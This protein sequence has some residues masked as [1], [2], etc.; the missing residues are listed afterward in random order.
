M[1]KIRIPDKALTLKT[2][3]GASLSD[4][5]LA[6]AIAVPGWGGGI[7]CCGSGRIKIVTHP[8]P[9]PTPAEQ[10]HLS[11]RE[12]SDN[13]R[14][15]CQVHPE[16]D[17]AI[18]L[19]A[20]NPGNQF[21]LINDDALPAHRCAWASGHNRTHHCCGLAVDLGTTRIQLTLWDLHKSKRLYGLSCVN[22]Q[23][24]FGADILNRLGKAAASAQTAETLSRLVTES[25]AIALQTCAQAIPF[26]KNDLQRSCV[27]AN[28]AMLTLFSGTNHS[29]LLDPNSWTREIDCN[30]DSYKRLKKACGLPDASALTLIPPVAGFIGSDLIAAVISSRLMS[31]PETALLIDFGTNSEIALWDGRVLWIASAAGGPAF[32][33]CGVTCGMPAGHGAIYAVQTRGDG[34]PPAFSVTGDTS[35]RG[36]CGSGLIDAVA[37]FLKTGRIHPSGRLAAPGPLP[38]STRHP[39]IALHNRDIDIFQRAKAAIG[40]GVATLLKCAH[41][42]V[43]KLERIILCGSF[44]NHLSI[45]NAQALGLLPSVAGHKICLLGNAALRGCELLLQSCDWREQVEAVKRHTRFVDLARTPLFETLYPCHLF[46][47]PF[48]Q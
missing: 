17:T 30:P 12:I 8:A 9:A 19:T 48:T 44:G 45:E 46:L 22:P 1:L 36:L 24:S 2:T 37:V 5:L 33:G 26:D 27:V 23:I 34:Q 14:L 42:P 11:P 32:D 43:Q 35:P 15:A 31:S 25:L 18:A 21:S 41:I 47:Q 3:R 6:N 38:I 39:E 16:H 40:A 7:G 4:T 10:R 29:L 20:T 28:T 13:I